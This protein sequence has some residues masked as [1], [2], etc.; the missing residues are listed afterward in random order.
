MPP[1]LNINLGKGDSLF[2]KQSQEVLCFE[3]LRVG[4]P[5]NSGC[6]VV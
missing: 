1:P 4:K 6:I 5:S 2:T 3:Q